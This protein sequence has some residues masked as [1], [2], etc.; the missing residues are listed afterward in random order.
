MYRV[1]GL[2]SSHLVHSKELDTQ[3]RRQEEARHCNNNN[4]C[5][6]VLKRLYYYYCTYKAM[7]K[8]NKKRRDEKYHIMKHDRLLLQLLHPVRK[9]WGRMPKSE[10]KDWH[11]E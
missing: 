8:N 3:H 5:A 1:K 9:R 4:A 6:C 11:K 2:T 7:G 10:Q